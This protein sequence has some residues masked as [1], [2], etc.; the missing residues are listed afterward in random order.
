MVEPAKAELADDEWGDFKA[1]VCGVGA[2]GL[3][4]LGFIGV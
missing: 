2:L 3:S 1:W 4:G